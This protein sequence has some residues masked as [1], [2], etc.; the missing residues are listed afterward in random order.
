MKLKLQVGDLPEADAK[1]PDNVLFVCKLN[2]VTTEEDLEVIFSRF[3]KI[4]RS[5]ADSNF[6][7]VTSFSAVVNNSTAPIELESYYGIQ[8]VLHFTS[9][10]ILVHNCGLNTA[11]VW[12]ERRHHMASFEIVR[13]L[14]VF[15]L[16]FLEFVIRCDLCIVRCWVFMHGC[17]T[18]HAR[19][20]CSLHVPRTFSLQRWWDAHCGSRWCATMWTHFWLLFVI[21]CSCEVIK[22]QKTSNSLQ[23]A[24][25]EFEN[26]SNFLNFF[27][28]WNIWMDLVCGRCW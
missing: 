23:Y 28:T 14:P 9:I 17:F 22:D 8:G 24:F 11:K 6:I 2:P 21:M 19:S 3:G 26:V 5:A 12:D 20:L 1:P 27:L 25:I 18:S 10:L 15:C 16:D 13:S 4:L 7:T